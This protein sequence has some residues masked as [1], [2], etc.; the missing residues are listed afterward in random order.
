M[1]AQARA[2]ERRCRSSTAAAT[3]TDDAVK[4]ANPKLQPGDVVF[5]YTKRIHRAPPPPPKG[6]PRYTLFG[7][8]CRADATNFWPQTGPD[9]Y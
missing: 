3:A 7:A 1:H 6:E 9:G 4:S 8:F 2:T 5:F